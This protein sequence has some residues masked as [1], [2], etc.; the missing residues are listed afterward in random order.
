MNKIA[1]DLFREW[2]AEADSMSNSSLRN[3]SLEQREKTINRFADLKNSLQRSEQQMNPVLEQMKE[4]VL[5]LKH[6]L[7]SQSIGS[8][9]EETRDIKLGMDRLT[10]TMTS[11]ISEMD[12]FLKSF[13]AADN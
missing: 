2:K 13:S 11:S 10:D 8:L 6:N 5:F 12:S 7:N 9:R 1:S 4:Y 3:R